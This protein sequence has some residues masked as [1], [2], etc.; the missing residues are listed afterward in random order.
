MVAGL[1]FLS[2]KGFNPQNNSNR[3]KVWEREQQ[4][5]QDA[6]RI[7]DRI[8]QLKRER[9]DE[10]LAI[11]RGDSVKVN[12]MYQL[13]PG[14]DA[15]SANKSDGDDE[16]GSKTNGD[17][18]GAAAADFAVHRQ[19]GDD[20]A[21]AA[22]RALLAGQSTSEKDT[23]LQTKQEEL[24][25]GF[26]FALRG[27]GAGAVTHERDSRKRDAQKL[28]ALEKAAG[29]ASSKLNHGLSLKSQIERF[30][31]LANAPRAQG[32]SSE[33]VG[34]NF[35]P[36]G[37]QIR[38]VKCLAC[39][40][41]GHARGERECKITGW[42]PFEIASN[43]T[44]HYNVT[45][46]SE[47]AGQTR[48]NKRTDDGINDLPVQHVQTHKRKSSSELRHDSD[49]SDGEDGTNRKRKHKRKKYKKCHRDENRKR[50]R[51]SK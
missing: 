24:E 12:F 8:A 26:N 17:A 11:A 10:E 21:A 43:V 7:R 30:P 50:Q 18:S 33:H 13:P 40:V 46:A 31:S 36:M 9:D 47:Q 37:A 38:N 29:R 34:V 1:K 51:Q 35:K 4:A 39:G 28:T 48:R 32:I 45:G 42:N 3:Q 2:K 41:W 14:L 15:A 19:A 23:L 20:D 22:F 44:R 25:D 16:E 27:S 49:S 6:K 5:E